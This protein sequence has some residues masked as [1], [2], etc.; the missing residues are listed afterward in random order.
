MRGVKAL[1]SGMDTGH[2]IDEHLGGE[3]LDVA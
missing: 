1:S 3:R 2:R